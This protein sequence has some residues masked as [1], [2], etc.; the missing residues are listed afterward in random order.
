[1]SFFN[2]AV[3]FRSVFVVAFAVLAA[4]LPLKRASA[5]TP[6]KFVLN[7]KTDAAAAPLLVA[8]DKGYFKAEGLNVSVVEPVLPEPN[9]QANDVAKRIAAGDAEMGLGDINALI[10]LRGAPTP[11]AVKAVYIVHNKPAYA[12]IGRKSRGIQVPRDLEGKKIGAPTRDPSTAEWKIFTKAN[13]LD[14]AKIKIENVGMPVREPMLAAGQV[15]AVTAIS[16]Y[17]YIDLKDR[18]VPTADL[19]VMLMADHGVKLYGDAI[20]V[21]Q[22][23]AD[24]NPEAVRAFLRAYN[25]GLKETVARPASAI[26]SVLRRVEAAHKDLELERLKMI[27][28]DNI[29]TRE[30]KAHGYG[31]IDP[32]RFQAAIDQIAGSYEF[33]PKPAV[34]DIFDSSFLPSSA[35]RKE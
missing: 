31:A 8:I 13:G 20:M 14:P 32:E 24:A 33:K 3:P 10:R 26:G 7:W 12:V 22:K 35:Q 18:G 11:P 25:K 4:A 19:T 21:S 27:I 34:D 28:N 6:V 16:Y 23:F 2:P 9:E 1:M 29:R 17:A 5:E 30:T 15:D